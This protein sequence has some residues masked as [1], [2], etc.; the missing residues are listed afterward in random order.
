MS[1]RP[2]EWTCVL[3]YYEALCGKC[4]AG[5][6]LPEYDFSPEKVDCLIC[7]A[8]N[9]TK[10]ASGPDPSVVIEDI[11]PD[12]GLPTREYCL[13][14]HA[15][16]GGGNNR[17]R[18]DLELAMGAPNVSKDLDVHMA[19]NMTCQDCHTFDGHHVAGQGMDLRTADSDTIVSCDRCHNVNEPPH[20]EGSMYNKHMDRIACTTCHPD[21]R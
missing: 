16:A 3:M 4:H 13:R 7:H 15:T 14:C 17:K 20:P 6:G 5:F 21:F 2:P 12:I 10:T 9:Y 8:P 1:H 11:T 19:A 18:G